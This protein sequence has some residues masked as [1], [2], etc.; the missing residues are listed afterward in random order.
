[1]T[2]LSASLAAIT[3]R[4]ATGPG[5]V[6]SRESTRSDRTGRELLPACRRAWPRLRGI[7][8]TRDWYLSFNSLPTS[9]Q[10]G[11]LSPNARRNCAVAA[12]HVEHPPALWQVWQTRQTLDD[13]CGPRRRLARVLGEH[14]LFDTS[15]L[16]I[17]GVLGVDPRDLCLPNLVGRL[18][19]GMARMA[20]AQSSPRRPWSAIGG[21]AAEGGILR[22][23][24]DRC[25]S[26]D[27][28]G[29]RRDA[30]LLVRRFGKTE[31]ISWSVRRIHRR[32]SVHGVKPKAESIASQ[33]LGGRQA[34][35]GMQAAGVQ[36][37]VAGCRFGPDARAGRG[38]A[39]ATGTGWRPGDWP[40][41]RPPRHT[42]RHGRPR[43]GRSPSALRFR[44]WPGHP[45]RNRW[46]RGP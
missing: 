9:D 25:C 15:A 46:R 22:D 6:R 30:V 32:I 40:G 14:R 11:N 42:P 37:G 43:P 29:A 10:A 2:P 31:R 16:M 17:N 18:L 12:T 41:V 26:A 34:E 23:E 28:T 38:D 24:F 7:A 5:C 21:N 33:T 3:P 4:K 19:D 36:R 20:N 35:L 45:P 13:S 44:P 27:M 39:V 1:M 8:S